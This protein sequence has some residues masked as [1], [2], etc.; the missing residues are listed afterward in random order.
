[1]GTGGP[2]LLGLVLTSALGLR[3]WGDG[4]AP[5]GSFTDLGGIGGAG[6]ELGEPDATG[7]GFYLVAESVELG[8]D[9]GQLL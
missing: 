5:D 8:L 2:P 7:D 3:C 4:D 1:M 6:L 9:A